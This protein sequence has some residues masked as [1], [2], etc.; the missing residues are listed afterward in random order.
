[1]PG[2]VWYILLTINLIM[3]WVK[4]LSSNVLITGLLISFLMS[5]PIMSY[6]DRPR[7]IAL[8]LTLVIINNESAKLNRDGELIDD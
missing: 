3:T 2:F 5:L 4:K 6:I 7:I 1:M 8:T